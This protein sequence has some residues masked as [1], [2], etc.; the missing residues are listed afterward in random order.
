MWKLLTGIL[1]DKLYHCLHVEGLF[2]DKQKRRR[3]SSH[4]TKDE[5]LFDK[6][7]LREAGFKQRCLT[8]GWIY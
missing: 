6:T 7:L 5:L 2:P 4:G 8:M 3:K 1:A